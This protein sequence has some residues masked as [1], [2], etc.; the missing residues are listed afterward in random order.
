MLNIQTSIFVPRGRNSDGDPPARVRHTASYPRGREGVGD[1][2][3]DGGSG[4]EGAGGGGG[5][6]EGEK[7][8][9]DEEEE[10]EQEEK[11]EEEDGE[12]GKMEA[13]DIS[14]CPRLDQS[15]VRSETI[16][17]FTPFSPVVNN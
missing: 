1:E 5:V 9:L 12:G 15:I 3:G 8:E 17:K 10:K 14:S 11:E 16:H 13:E 7:E 6:K 2:G 4:R